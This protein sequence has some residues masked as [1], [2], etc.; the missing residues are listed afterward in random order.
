M[1]G[2][3]PPPQ[4]VTLN[5][6][7]PKPTLSLNVARRRHVRVGAAVGTVGAP[8]L[9]LRAIDLDVR[10]LE[11]LGVEALDLREPYTGGSHTSQFGATT[12]NE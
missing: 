9:L 8:P 1:T 11:R 2:V 10:D 3:S 6:P 7:S 5:G 12:S 4:V